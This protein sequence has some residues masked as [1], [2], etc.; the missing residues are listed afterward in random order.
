MQAR[1]FV[2][3]DHPITRIGVSCYLRECAEIDLVGSGAWSD[4]T[5]RDA[6]NSDPDVLIFDL[7]QSKDGR[8][9]LRRLNNACPRAKLLIFTG[10]SRLEDT[11]YALE[12]GASGMVTK[13]GDPEHLR[14]AILRLV[15][16]DNYLEPGVA[17]QVIDA[18]KKAESRRNEVSTLRL[19]HR[20]EQVLKCL[21]KGRT[22]LQIA[23]FLDI[24]EKTVKY[25]VGCLKDKFNAANR[26]E[27]VLSAQR[28]A[29][30]G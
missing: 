8:A 10:D 14:H 27:I 29:I 25:Y 3:D 23:E 15:R 19:T 7:N 11:V 20:E 2:C 16:G 9:R 17:M 30:A 24:S 5:I 12:A 6:A 4:E 13:W 21:L 22:N 18:L 28:F 26:L 1:V